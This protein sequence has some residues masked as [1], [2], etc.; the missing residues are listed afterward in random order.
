MQ[1]IFYMWNLKNKTIFS[2]ENED[3]QNY[4]FKNKQ[5]VCLKVAIIIL[6]KYFVILN[7]IKKL[8]SG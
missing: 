4:G 1:V 8:S 7:M 2:K 3:I 6:C 5:W